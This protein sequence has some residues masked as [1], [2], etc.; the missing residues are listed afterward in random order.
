VSLEINTYCHMGFFMADISDDP[1]GPSL[2]HIPFFLMKV[3]M[4]MSRGAQ[5]LLGSVYYLCVNMELA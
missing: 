2:A 1:S 3:G 4:L 5:N